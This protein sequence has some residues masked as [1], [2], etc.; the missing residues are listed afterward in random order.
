MMHIPR[1]TEKLNMKA[2]EVG[3]ALARKWLE[4]NGK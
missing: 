4:E 3:T 2:L 1:G